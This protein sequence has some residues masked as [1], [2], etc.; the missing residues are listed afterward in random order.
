MKSTDFFEAVG[1]VDDSLLEAA[2]NAKVKKKSCNTWIK[3][4]TMAA[5]FCIMIASAIVVPGLFKDEPVT[6]PGPSET[7]PPSFENE[8]ALWNSLSYFS[9][10]SPQGNNGEGG[11]FSTRHTTVILDEQYKTYISEA[12]VEEKYIKEQIATVTVKAFWTTEEFGYNS[13]PI[14]GTEETVE[15]NVYRID[16]VD[17]S[18]AVALMFKEKADALTTTHYYVYMNKD[19]TSDTI[20]LLWQNSN[21]SQFLSTMTLA[22][23]SSFTFAKLDADGSVSETNYRLTEADA[24]SIKS[25]LLSANGNI[26][27]KSELELHATKLGEAKQQLKGGI[28]LFNK[29][30]NLQ[31]TNNG[32][33]L[34]D[35]QLYFVGEETT[36]KLFDLVKSG[37]VINDFD[38]VEMTTQASN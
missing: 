36:N 8:D 13:K 21:A 20:Q 22:N 16:G 30:I 14:E 27:K 35:D 33:L 32:Y 1:K 17:V 15:A 6:P 34:I 9:W 31:I 37:T 11:V 4:G 7:N 29:Y 28:R 24:D 25:V 38:I 3:W 2:E 18:M 10:M 23:G 5:C 19:Y 12:V 26:V